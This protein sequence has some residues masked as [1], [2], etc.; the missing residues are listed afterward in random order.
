M[1]AKNGEFENNIDDVL[2]YIGTAFS[3]VF[4]DPKGWTG[5][6]LD[7]IKPILDLRGEVLINFMFDHINRFISAPEIAKTID[8]LFGYGNWFSDFQTRVS[9]FYCLILRP[10]H[11]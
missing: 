1:L 3:L 2:S 11:F 6:A 5:Y 10:V 9:F 4:I 7:K 8:P